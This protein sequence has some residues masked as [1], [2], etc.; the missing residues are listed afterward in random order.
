[1]QLRLTRPILLMGLPQA[2]LDG[3]IR[4]GLFFSPDFGI[5]PK[6]N[7][8]EAVTLKVILEGQLFLLKG[9]RGHKTRWP[10][11]GADVRA[12][13]INSRN[14]LHHRPAGVFYSDLISQAPQTMVD[15]RLKHRR[16]YRL[17]LYAVDFDHQHRLENSLR[18]C[19]PSPIS[20]GENTWSLSVMGARE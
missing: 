16:H 5:R 12:L 6:E 1:M 9:H 8:K 2:S 15:I 10:T 11:S 4:R 17:A 19:R 20:P 3:L 14:G 18:P 7:T 13:A